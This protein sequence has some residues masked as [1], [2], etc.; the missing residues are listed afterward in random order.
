[1]PLLLKSKAL[2]ASSRHTTQI[3]TSLRMSPIR[4]GLLTCHAARL[5]EA[6]SASSSR[7][8][9]FRGAS[10]SSVDLRVKNSRRIL[11]A[12]PRA[13]ATRRRSKSGRRVLLGRLRWGILIRGYKRTPSVGAIPRIDPRIRDGDDENRKSCLPSEPYP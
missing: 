12:R 2:L 1:M 3:L 11:A 13:G 9:T 6:F 4:I 8:D 7:R 10:W 5:K